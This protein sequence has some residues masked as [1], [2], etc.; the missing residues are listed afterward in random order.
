MLS[1]ENLRDQFGQEYGNTKDFKKEF[2]DVMRQTLI[3]YPEAHVSSILPSRRYRGR[4][5]R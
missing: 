5:S 4:K 2:K 1:W 3:V